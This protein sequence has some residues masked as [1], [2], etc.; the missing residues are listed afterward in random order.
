MYARR[1]RFILDE[2]NKL[3][4]ENDLAKVLVPGE[5]ADGSYGD[6]VALQ[7]DDE[8]KL[9]LGQSD[10]SVQLGLAGY[11]LANVNLTQLD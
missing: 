4:L 1:C 2:L 5:V 3:V 8:L 9:S 7:V 6:T 10:Y 11:S